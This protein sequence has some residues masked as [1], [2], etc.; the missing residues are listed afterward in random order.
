[1]DIAEQ[2]G[3][4]LGFVEAIEVH[5]GDRPGSVLDLGS[6]GGPPG[7]VLAACWPAT[8]TVLVEANHRRAEFLEGWL[9]RLGRAGT[10]K[11]VTDRA[12]VL[13]HQP[14]WREAFEFVTARSFGR[15][16]VTAECGAAFLAVGGRLVVSE[17]PEVADDDA[18]WPAA[19]LVLFGLVRPRL[20]RAA[21]FGYRVME[22]STPLDA[23][24]PRRTGVP[25]KRPMF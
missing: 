17:P 13:G 20:Q 23:R 6:G 16:A 12:E 15:P 3:H 2:L 8:R 21:G 24:Y 7:L 14:E 10:A 19:G 18:R 4:A 1:M 25:A 11:V 9:D 22:K 5:A